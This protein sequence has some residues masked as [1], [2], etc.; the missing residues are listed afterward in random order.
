MFPFLWACRAHHQAKVSSSHRFSLW[1]SLQ[2]QQTSGSCVKDGLKQIQYVSLDN[3]KDISA[4]SRHKSYLQ[5]RNKLQRIYWTCQ[6]FIGF[7]F[8]LGFLLSLP[9][10]NRKRKLTLGKTR[11]SRD[12]AA[13][14]AEV[15]ELPGATQPDSQNP[16]AGEGVGLWKKTGRYR[17]SWT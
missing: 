5:V 8:C 7:V 11:Q 9:F 16:A 14:A 10:G 6:K 12:R 1:L 17:H 13:A 15:A 3:Q 4:C 2:R